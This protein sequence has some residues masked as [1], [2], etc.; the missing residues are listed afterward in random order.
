VAPRTSFQGN[1]K[2]ELLSRDPAVGRAYEA[3]PLVHRRASARFFTEFK[4]AIAN[5]TDRGAEIRVPILV[6]QAGSD[7]LVDPRATAAFA[8]GIPSEQKTVLVYP[9]LYHEI[10]NETEKERVFDDLERWL[11]A[12]VASEEVAEPA[13]VQAA[14]R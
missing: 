1:V 10:F 3:D 13:R 12:L 4:W 11:D 6:L 9:G 7:G 5:V 2:P 8:A 14:A